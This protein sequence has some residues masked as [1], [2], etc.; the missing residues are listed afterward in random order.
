MTAAGLVMVSTALAF[1]GTP[2]SKMN[3]YQ[4]TNAVTDTTA[5]GSAAL[6][7]TCSGEFETVMSKL[8]TLD[9]VIYESEFL[10]GDVA[11]F[12]G[13]HV[14][15]YIGR[16]VWMDSSRQRAGVQKFSMLEELAANDR[17]WYG[18]PINVERIARRKS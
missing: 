18:G 13:G 10:P 15:V 14:A 6:S 16:G 8:S 3:C 5:C 17:G 7:S 11:Q 2:Y 9:L 12:H 1:Q 4:F